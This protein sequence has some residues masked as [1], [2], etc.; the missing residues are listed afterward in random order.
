MGEGTGSGGALRCFRRIRSHGTLYAGERRTT[1]KD[2]KRRSARGCSTRCSLTLESTETI[3]RGSE[4]WRCPA[5]EIDPMPDTYNYPAAIERDEDGRYV[6]VFPDLA[7][8]RRMGP[9]WRKRWAKR[10]ICC[11]S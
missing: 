5:R 10:G 1:V 6:V 8:E 11:A 9:R 2:R 3:S 7:G 4:R